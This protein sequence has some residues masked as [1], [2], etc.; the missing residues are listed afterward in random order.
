MTRNAVYRVVPTR[1]RVWLLEISWR[2]LAI[3]LGPILLLSV[4]A[5]W[6]AIRLVRPAP[7]STI[8]ITAGADGSIFR[9]TAEK[10]RKILARNGVTLQILPSEGSLENLKRLNDS[11]LRVDIGFVQGGV[12]ATTPVASLISL[13]SVFHEPLAVFYRAATPVRRL[14]ELRGKRL[15]IGPEGSGTRFLALT[16]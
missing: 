15:A 3:T 12:A 7:P 13:G 8:T 9:I 1:F 10:Y 5:A 4:A 6:V 2:D 14:S 11:S 16:L